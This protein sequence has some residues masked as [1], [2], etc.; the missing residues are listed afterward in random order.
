MASS[1]SITPEDLK[2]AIEEINKG[3]EGTL[4]LAKNITKEL[5]QQEGTYYDMY[6]ANDEI[7]QL[8][9]EMIKNAKEF[10]EK[11]EQWLKDAEKLADKY[12]IA[13]EEL[14]TISEAKEKLKKT[15]EELNSIEDGTH[16][17][18]EKNRKIKE[19]I[20]ENEKKINDLDKERIELLK[21]LAKLEEEIK[22]NEEYLNDPNITQVEKIHLKK[23][24]D[25]LL[26]KKSDKEKEILDNNNKK[27]GIEDE[28]VVN[29][30]EKKEN[31][32]KIADLK[33]NLSSL[34]PEL[35]DLA[36]A[37]EPIAASF[38]AASANAEE[39]RGRIDEARA[40]V[41]ALNENTSFLTSLWNGVVNE[42][43]GAA[44]YWLEVN[45]RA[46]KLSRAM[47][48]G[49]DQAKAFFDAQ[50]KQTQQL[51]HTYGMT[52]EELMKFQQS[53]TDATGRAIFLTKAETEE[54]AAMSKLSSPEIA[55]D[56]VN[57]L[58]KMGM[59]V[60]DVSTV[61][62]VAETRARALGLN[63]AK[64]TEAV[65]KNIDKLNKYNF[66]S[67][68]DGLTRMVLRA[69]ELRVSVDDMIGAVE[70]FGSIEDAM[71]NSAKLQMLGGGFAVGGSNPM[72]LM[73]Q[74][75]ADPT[76]LAKSIEGMVKGLAVMNRSTGEMDV[77]AVDYMR[78]KAASEALGM[79]MESLVQMTKSLAKE[80]E[81]ASY[82]GD[83]MDQFT[84][85]QKAM[86]K[87]KA[88]WDAETQSF[89]I[90]IIGEDGKKVGQKDIKNITAKD[91]E[92]LGENTI[93]E[94]NAFK[95]IRAIANVVT[96]RRFRETTKERAK[97]TRSTTE[98]VTGTR[99]TKLAVEAESITPFM[100]F[101]D[102]IVETTGN[103]LE[104]LGA[105]GPIV[106]AITLLGIGLLTG[107]FHAMGNIFD[108]ALGRMT[109]RIAGRMTTRLGGRSV[110]SAM[111]AS[112]RNF[113]SKTANF[114]KGGKVG[115]ALGKAGNILKGAGK[116]L[117]NAGKAT[118]NAAGKMGS[119]AAK[120]GGKA[121]S[122]TAKYG[123]KALNWGK[124]LFKGG[125]SFVKGIP[126][127]AAILGVAEGAYSIYS[128][129]KERKEKE[130]QIENASFLN[131]ETKER[132]K[133]RARKEQV[134]K[135]TGGIGSAAGALGG[136][137]LGAAIGSFIAPGIGT[138]I[139]GALGAAV[140]SV[141]GSRVG[142]T[143][144]K[145]FTNALGEKQTAEQKSK[146]DL[147]VAFERQ[148][149]EATTIEDP[150]VMEKGA[151]ATI[152]IH[153]LLVTHFNK[154]DG[155]RED[156]T[157]KGWLSKVPLIGGFFAQGGIVKA[158]EGSVVP[159][160]SY[161]GDK[162]PVMANSGEM[163]L[164]QNQQK[165]LFNILKVGLGPL[166]YLPNIIK[167]LTGE[168]PDANNAKADNTI[169]GIIASS[170]SKAF[171]VGK[172]VEQGARS[173]ML[174]VMKMMTPSLSLP[175]SSIMPGGLIGGSLFGDNG[176]R[177]FDIVK[178]VA[179][180]AIKNTAIG[181]L[182][183]GV[184]NLFVSDTTEKGI[185]GKD[186]KDITPADLEMS[187]INGTVNENNNAISSIK[188]TSIKNEYESTQTIKNSNIFSRIFDLGKNA[189]K[190]AIKN[191]PIYQNYKA[192]TKL[193]G[194]DNT[195]NINGGDVNTDNV[196]KSVTSVR[197]SVNSSING[198]T[199]NSST[200]K[201]ISSVNNGI[202]TNIDNETV[203]NGGTLSK[204][205][206]FVNK[207][208]KA[209]IEHTPIYQK[210]K[211]MSNLLGG[212]SDTSIAEGSVNNDYVSNTLASVKSGDITN[213]DNIKR[214]DIAIEKT[215]VDVMKERVERIV[216]GNSI[217]ASAIQ[218]PSIKP[219]DKIGEKTIIA[220]SVE[221]MQYGGNSFDNRDINLNINGSIRLEG[222]G[223]GANFN[224]NELLKDEGF[225]RQLTEIVKSRL[226]TEG[227]AS[228]MNKES[229]TINTQK[230]YNGV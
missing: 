58:S 177:P 171:G 183:S 1:V 46:F 147:Q 174:G 217:N 26:Q 186:F 78:I 16:P 81:V 69:Q 161:S 131:E 75:M 7:R 142:K 80:Q 74:S 187:T 4:N 189:V 37:G 6:I 34:K 200:N 66:R 3:N 49:R 28:N 143:I 160:N 126:G 13:K 180:T 10:E 93:D 144:G 100:Y 219:V 176:G 228:K 173:S 225:K 168:Q 38:A 226:N 85:A 163:I 169:G 55:N 111:G 86:L 2:K 44:K 192:L 215:P 188:D 60:K 64:A 18:I 141:A 87:N 218:Q 68:V 199:I 124:N 230:I 184:K 149:I 99:E 89:K 65:S 139:G 178:N 197:N 175:V 220:P 201:N 110:S 221:R 205:K 116:I 9:D 62:G 208:V 112:M 132:E 104:R 207:V 229:S 134:E 30:N 8:M 123:G 23:K 159:G 167:G 135:T 146:S 198:D 101:Y 82:M 157:K 164:N 33:K 170:I 36:T 98:K 115:S 138:A 212:K 96:G 84:D 191:T 193:F 76:A 158:A 196:A 42:I 25:E 140:G 17:L 79:S 153:S 127:A 122:S 52:Q 51:A 32:K 63:A 125:G 54:M 29:K 97:A 19:N 165:N 202:E 71:Q 20:A 61:F 103:I 120:Y 109:T 48:A 22:K 204:V 206:N 150:Q 203:N 172:N 194:Y 15:E 128:A 50:I 209:T 57:G 77:S 117:G 119:A 154:K 94:E 210:Y 27:E 73:Y 227:N 70:K 108:K 67:G 145:V 88:Q 31:E 5:Q 148:K 39:F 155:L 91:L 151:L 162:V 179:K 137:K 121:V 129:N 166:S 72:G 130:K 214:G 11:Q 106:R 156:G 133:S 21:E 181:R 41:R 12:G 59:S 105:G 47:G 53:Y 113:G 195:T 35:E 24:K 152:A 136:A 102:T 95:D 223:L 222:Q 185:N 14:S 224:L 216:N 213:I 83:S 45:D 182:V 92:A 43:K 40:S 118:L 190:N 90:D 211:I 56:L 107:G 114:F